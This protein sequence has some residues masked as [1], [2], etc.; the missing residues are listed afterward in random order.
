MMRLS[1]EAPSTISRPESR[2]FPR[3]TILASVLWRTRHRPGCGMAIEAES[4]GAPK[5]LIDESVL[6]LGAF[7]H[8]LGWETVAV[9]S[10]TS[11]DDIVRLA[12]AN[13]YVVVTPDRRL[14][15]RCRAA[16]IEVVDVGFEDLARRVHQTLVARG[17]P[18]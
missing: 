18:K 2:W 10:G 15:A 13:G 3:L 16:G 5:L 9:K 1:H 17:T 7:L 4:T 12:R 14:L 8:D 11:D 6:G